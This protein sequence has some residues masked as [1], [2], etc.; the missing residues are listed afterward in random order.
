MMTAKAEIAR[1]EAELE[2]VKEDRARLLQIF[3]EICSQLDLRKEEL[4]E[5][6]RRDIE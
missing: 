4:E 2:Q 3:S 5:M 1:L 6:M